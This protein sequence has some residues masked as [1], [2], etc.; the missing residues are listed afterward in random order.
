MHELQT[1]E[2]ESWRPGIEF[3]ER[4]EEVEE[5]AVLV[6]AGV[7]AEVIDA[8]FDFWSWRWPAEIPFLNIDKGDGE[9]RFGVSLRRLCRTRGY[10]DLVE[11]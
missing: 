9:G 10:L 5:R 7:A 1:K 4:K 8:I 2:Q 6:V 3:V 11:K